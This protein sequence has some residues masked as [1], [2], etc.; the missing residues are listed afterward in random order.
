VSRRGGGARTA[1]VSADRTRADGPRAPAR[2]PAVAWLV[3]AGML[4]AMAWLQHGALRAPF[5]AD[6]YAFLDAVGRRTFAG[7]LTAPDPLGNYLRPVGRQLWFWLIAHPGSASPAL[8]HA[9]GLALFIGVVALLFVLVAGAAGPRAGLVAAAVLAL[10]HAAD[11]PVWWVSGAQD[12]LAVI[13]ALAALVLFTRGW[14]WPAALVFLVGIL[15]KETIALTP[16]VAVALAPAYGERARHALRRVWPLGLALGLWAVVWLA[17]LPGRPAFA[18]ETHVDARVWPAALVGLARAALGIEWSE[19][20][21]PARITGSDLAAPLVALV[22]LGIGLVWLGGRRAASDIDRPATRATARA[23]IVWGLAGALPVAVV[24]PI[25]SAYHFLFAVCGC[26]ALAGALLANAAPAGA[27]I[28]VALV[29]ALSAHTRAL[30]GFATRPGSLT[31]QSHVTRSYLV[32]GMTRLEQTLDMVR[33]ARP[34]LPPHSTLL[35]SGVPANVAFQTGD[36]PVVRWAYRDTTLR[37]RFLGAF[38]LADAARGPVFFFETRNDTLREVTGPDSLRDLGRRLMVGD[39][40]EAS[41]DLLE[42]R[43]RDHPDDAGS[44]YPLAL[45][46][47]ATGDDPGGRE[48]LGRAG[49]TAAGGPVPQIGQAFEALSAR[50]TARAIAVTRAGVLAHALDPGVHALLADLEL[51]RDRGSPNG[52]LEAYATVV[53]GPEDA[54]AWRRWAMVLALAGRDRA[55]SAALDRYAALAGP[56]AASDPLARAVREQITPRLPG[57]VEA[58]RAISR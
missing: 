11:V 9:L 14:V 41:R 28:A 45:L 40:P 16:L 17:T 12:L 55:A 47:L 43:V 15:A 36:G 31:P 13:A 44:W 53:L 52:A 20:G 39:A 30:P 33:R 24:M 46:R 56:G 2:I 10:H 54:L 37:S 38:R 26:A 21:A 34:V 51:G 22:A 3:L 23:A 18:S 27:V 35:F 48:A 6:D 32:R 7:A 58:E 8:A 25:W 42:L 49:F 57:G 5:F 4:A 29:A 19:S 50:D 1:A